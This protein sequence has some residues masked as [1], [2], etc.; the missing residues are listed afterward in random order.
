MNPIGEIVTPFKYPNIDLVESIKAENKTKDIK[1]FISK[2][3]E[4]IKTLK[5]KIKDL[6][7]RSI[8]EIKP[9]NKDGVEYIIERIDNVDL[10]ELATN[11]KKRYKSYLGKYRKGKKIFKLGTKS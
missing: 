7:N 9:I 3:K 1:T 2:Q 4:E 10:R 8:N 5:Q 11:L 6:Q